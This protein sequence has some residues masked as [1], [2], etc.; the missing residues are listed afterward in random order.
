M[1]S[2]VPDEKT[3]PNIRQNLCCLPLM[4]TLVNYVVHCCCLTSDPLAQWQH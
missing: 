4:L 1:D 3:D 2:I